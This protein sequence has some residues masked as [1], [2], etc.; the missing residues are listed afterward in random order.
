MKTDDRE[1]LFDNLKAVLIILVVFGHVME[2]FGLFP[3]I[4]CVIYTFHMPLFI[5]ISGYFSKDT[6][7]KENKLVKNL[8]IP[9]FLFNTIYMLTIES[10]YYTTFKERLINL[11][12]F[13]ASYLYWYLISLFIWRIL[14]KYIIKFKYSMVILFILSLYIGLINDAGRFLSI[15]RTT[16]F[17][18]FFM[19]G[20]YTNKEYIEKI[21]N[22][23]KKIAIFILIILISITFI[24]A[25][26]FINADL[27]FNAQSYKASGVGIFR[28]IFVRIYQ[29]IVATVISICLINV[30]SSKN[31]WMSIMGSK[32]VSIYILSP[33][34]QEVLYSIIVI[35]PLNIHM[36]NPITLFI[37]IA[38]AYIIIII[39]SLE[40]VYNTYNKVIDIIYN[41]VTKNIS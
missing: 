12:I 28:G 21:R 9:F 34:V 41:K 2:R 32:T 26:K 3:K 36:N 25:N 37:C 4:R 18:P 10:C 22:M 20:Y 31:N 13:R 40:I 14:T 35:M 15:S 24:L 38:L 27:F 30:I 19:L 17:F 29:F 16:A 33:F 5:F 39:C 11:N 1:Y 6:T 7:N 23:N 8:L